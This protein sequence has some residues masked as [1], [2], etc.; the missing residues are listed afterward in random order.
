MNVCLSVR[1]RWD[2]WLVEWAMIAFIKHTNSPRG[3]I[4][5]RNQEAA[6]KIIPAAKS[7]NPYAKV[8]FV[9]PDC[10]LLK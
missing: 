8:I 4:I 1:S 7:S 10:T 5:G 6:Q 3:Y 2:E 9:S